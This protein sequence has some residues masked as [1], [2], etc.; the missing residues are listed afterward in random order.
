MTTIPPENASQSLMTRLREVANL[1]RKSDK[2]NPETQRAV[3]DLVEELSKNLALERV[4][5]AELTHLAENTAHLAESLVHRHDAGVLGKIREG[6][7]HAA[8][9]AEAHAPGAV[10]LARRFIE[11]LANIG[12]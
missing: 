11:T 9:N 8:A 7:D 1:L 2:V 4:P 6:L 3:A 5:S 12:I 10:D